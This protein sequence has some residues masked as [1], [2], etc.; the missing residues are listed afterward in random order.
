MFNRDRSF[1]VGIASRE[2]IRFQT[3]R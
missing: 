3:L 2:M 1:K